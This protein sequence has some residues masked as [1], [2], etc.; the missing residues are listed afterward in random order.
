[1]IVCDFRVIFVFG[2]GYFVESVNRFL[3]EMV[4]NFGVDFFY[5]MDWDGIIFVVF[6]W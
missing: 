2:F 6:N 3:E 1:M 4:V 5:V